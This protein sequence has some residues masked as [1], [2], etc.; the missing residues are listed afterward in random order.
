MSRAASALLLLAIVLS[1]PVVAGVS[2]HD[3]LG[4]PVNLERPAQRIVTLAPHATELVIAAGAASRLV[5][6]A[7]GHAPPPGLADLPR[8]GAAGSLDR[9]ALLALQPDLV[10]AWHSGNR[11]QDLAWLQRL[12]VA[13]YRTE[14]GRLA[15]IA[16]A[17][18]GIGRLA[19]SDAQ[20]ARAARAFEQAL[21]TPCAD[22]AP[23]PAVV[24]VWD[25]PPMTVG[26]RHW[27]NAV[28]GAAG[29]VNRFA[30]VAAGTFVV[31][32]EALLASAPA[33]RISLLP[34]AADDAEL[35]DLLSRPG[36]H[37]PRA[38]Q[39]LCALRLIQG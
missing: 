16:A 30:G 3:D 6:I 34:G 15:D 14:P 2:A 8:L 25:R 39:R 11:P 24:L 18:R 33:L 19:G 36:P 17:I 10:I 12:G 27:I 9:E 35:A 5:A 1:A 22:L 13:V 37:L 29:F 23:R 20:A 28:L 4:R 21:H 26:G 32:P 7:A 38:V 31:A